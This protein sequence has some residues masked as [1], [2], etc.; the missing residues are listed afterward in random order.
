MNKKNESNVLNRTVKRIAGRGNTCRACRNMLRQEEK[1][2][3]ETLKR[4]NSE[5]SGAKTTTLVK[6]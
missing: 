2:D 3:L 1:E 4:F 6:K 5:D